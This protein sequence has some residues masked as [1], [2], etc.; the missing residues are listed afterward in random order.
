MC[1][2]SFQ[3]YV[4][5]VDHLLS[6]GLIFTELALNCTLA[7]CQDNC[8]VTRTGSM[9]YCKSGYEISQDRKSCKGRFAHAQFH[10]DKNGN[11]L[12]ERN[13]K[14]CCVY[15]IRLRRVYD[16]RHLQSDVYEHGRLIHLLLR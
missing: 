2:I 7:G 15:V 6:C 3:Y 13:V 16:I 12:W 8:A 10:I 11:I 1:N 4:M 14:C 9:C 5:M